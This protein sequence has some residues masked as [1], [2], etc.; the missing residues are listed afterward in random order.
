MKKFWQQFS[1]LCTKNALL[2]IRNW[3][4]SLGQV[5]SPVVIVLLLLGFQKLTDYVL[6]RDTEFPG[7]NPL[8]PYPRCI[9]HNGIACK[10]IVFAPSSY[11]WVQD[12]MRNLA[13]R[14]GLDYEADFLPMD[15]GSFEADNRTMSNYIAQ[16]QN[17]TQNALLF[18]SAYVIRPPGK[19]PTE[20]GYLLMYNS[21]ADESF[22]TQLMAALDEVIL[23]MQANRTVTFTVQKTSF[24]KAKYRVTGYD[25]VASDGG[26]WFYVPMMVTFFVLLTE[27]VMEKEMRLRLGM[28]MMGLRTSVYWLVWLLNGAVFV[29]ASS[30]VLITTGMACGFNVFLN[31]NFGAV[32]LLFFLFGMAICS[33]AFFLSTL[34]KTARSAQTAGYA[35]I[36]VGFV[37]QTILCS[38]YGILVDILYSPDVA[39]WVTAVRWLLTFYPPFNLAKAYS[40]IAALSSDTIDLVAG[41]ITKGPGFH[42]SDVSKPRVLPRMFNLNLTIPPPSESL[43]VL[44]LL[45]VFYAILTW[46]FDNVLPGEHG[47]P[48]PFYFF[49]TPSYWGLTKYRREMPEAVES[50]SSANWDSDTQREYQ[51]ALAAPADSKS[52]LL[53][54]ALCKTFWGNMLV[55]TKKDFVAVDRLSFQV[56]QGTIFCLLGHNG[57]GK[58]T[59]IGMLTGLLTPTAG[60]ASVYGYDVVN[61]IDDVQ[62]LLGVCPQHDIVW[63]ELTAREHLRLF[64]RLKGIESELVE[65]EVSGKLDYMGLLHVADQR[66]GSFSGGMKRRLS[67]AIS[68][69]GDPKLIFMDEPTTGMDP[70]NKKAVWHLIQQMKKDCAIVLTTHSMEEA[71]TLGDRVGIMAFGKLRC[72]GNS[73][74]LKARY[75]RGYR[76]NVVTLAENTQRVISEVHRVAP[77]AEVASND[78]GSLGFGIDDPAET[79][80]LLK[81]LET[82]TSSSETSLDAGLVKEWGVSHTTLEEVFLEV[83]KRYNFKYDDEPDAPTP[84]A[85]LHQIPK[86]TG[87]SKPTKRTVRSYPFRAL[88]RKNF[89]LQRRQTGTNCCQIL[90]P[91]LV[92]A[93]LVL[94]QF[95]LRAE[96]GSNL[97]QKS[98]VPSMPQPLNIDESKLPPFPTAAS[99]SGL[100]YATAYT[101]AEKPDLAIDLGPLST[102]GIRRW[103]SVPPSPPAPNVTN[104]TS[105]NYTD[106]LGTCLTF[107][108]FADLTGAAGELTVNRSTAGLLG[109]IPQRN[110]TSENHTIAVPYFERRDSLSAMDSEVFDDLTYLNTIAIDDLKTSPY[111]DIVPD[112]IVEFNVIDASTL[113]LG[114]T[115]SANDQMMLDYHRANN[116]TRLDLPFPLSKSALDYT[117]VIDQ[118]NLALMDLIHSAF[119]DFIFNTTRPGFSYTGIKWVQPMP[120]YATADV[121]AILEAF[122]TFLYPVALTL[123]LPIYISIIAWE[124][125]E[126]L[127]EMMKSQGMRMSTYYFTNYLFNMVLYSLVIAFFWV[128]GVAVGIRFFTQTHWSTLL[129]FFIGWGQALIQLSFFL[130]TFIN[131]KRAAIVIGYVIALIGSL[132]G[133]VWCVGVYG[134]NEYTL[135][136]RLP[137]GFLVWPQ[138]AFIRGIYLMN[139]ACAS[140]YACYGSLATLGG[141]DELGA[142]MIALYVGAAALLLM[143]LYLDQVLPRTYGIPKHPLFFLF[144]LRDCVGSRPDTTPEHERL[145]AYTMVS[146]QPEDDDVATERERVSSGTHQSNAPLVIKELRKVYPDGPNGAKVAVK[147]LC[148]AVEQGEC[149]TLLGE[150]GAGKTTTI[151]MLTGVYQPTSGTATVGGFDIVT[152]IDQVHLAMGLCP[153]FSLLWSDLTVREHMLFYARLKGILPSEED[154]HVDQALREV[155]LLQS[156]EKLSK[157]LS[158]G[159]KRRLSVAISLVGDSEI[160]FLDEPTTGLDP[161]S[162]RQIWNILERAKQTRALVLTTHQMDEAELLSTRIGVLAHGELRCLGNQQHL[163]NKFGLGYNLQVN[164]KPVH[165]AV[166]HAFITS[167]FVRAE[168]IAVYTGTR[169]YRLPVEG[170]AVSNVFKVLEESALTYGITDWSFSQV[171]LEDVFQSIVE[172]SR[173]DEQQTKASVSPF[174]HSAINMS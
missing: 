109:K 10:T 111:R 9:Q 44:A 70:V 125:E 161:A 110:C 42:W 153:Q 72:I 143:A 80:A 50:E 8:G 52:A 155:G 19:L 144:W 37:F 93:I 71:E 77:R 43:V 167:V 173:P 58:T 39:H 15:S 120:Y 78:S 169:K 146:G 115:F 22:A 73:L 113:E 104:S 150:N 99:A 142:V 164:F 56:E 16:H 36:L 162:R 84:A 38:G 141:G 62:K 129:V 96:L 75:G 171:G 100:G 25:V 118:G 90:T 1:V 132:I 92:M 131:T 40:D 117:L 126:R 65:R 69:I 82:A 76:V 26:V 106:T 27:I 139:D 55:R 3:K 12:V 172:S 45:V 101:P 163:K 152:S 130:S 79:T 30:V 154:R 122:G 11:P 2:A 108:L 87:D 20:P 119:R 54:R 17:A 112:G 166:V 81:Y 85:E 61:D 89:A 103:F 157:A 23:S 140:K 174:D 35:I 46:Y 128:V 159:M 158:G 168:V 28:R 134:D 102:R 123:Q 4:G 66:V 7:V 121:L 114:Y 5:L 47:S 124:K 97:D 160:V 91:V 98:L 21:T 64:A 151:S 105:S 41:T 136:D 135:N 145:L 59:T 60:Q 88:M 33:F 49:L 127:R 32:F 116:F 14:T 67:V 170:V 63:N 53:L 68:A 147:S 86:S 74:H 149:F 6:D 48:R 156:A 95:I 31:S 51:E 137:T 148:L 34:L 57:A 94:L 83:S 107:F 165:E 13:T 29:A 133:L 138:F 18:T 24:P